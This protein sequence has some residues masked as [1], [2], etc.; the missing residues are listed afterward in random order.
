MTNKLFWLD[1]EAFGLVARHD[2]IIEV[3]VAVTDLELNILAECSWTIWS[4][5]H[6][7][8]FDAQQYNAELANDYP[9]NKLYQSEAFVL[10]MHTKSG[11]YADARET[12]RSFS[13]VSGQVVEFLERNGIDSKLD[14]MCGSSIRYDREMLA[15]WMPEVNDAFH[16][17][18]IDVSSLKEVARRYN[19]S[20]FDDI[21]AAYA[22]GRAAPSHRALDDIKDSIEEFRG[23]LNRLIVTA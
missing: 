18:I 13:Q 4:P 19:E 22:A 3:A 17:R 16:Y 2:P 8:R 11:L 20:A 6:R 23:Y 7:S 10:D 15:V 5:Q 1:S 14:P 12:G 9:Q 21:Q